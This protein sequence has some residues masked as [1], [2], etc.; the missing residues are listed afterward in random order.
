MSTIRISKLEAARRHLRAAI[1][2][3]FNGAD[4]VV[5]HTLVGVA[6]VLAAD[7]AKH[8]HPDAQWESWAQDANGISAQ[9]Y[10]AI[11]RSTQNFLKHADRDVDA[12]HEFEPIEADALAFG[13]TRNLANFGKLGLEE[14]AFELWYIACNDP[15]GC[16]YEDEI[17]AHAVE[18]FGDL[19][20]QNRDAQL[21]KGRKVLSS[22]PVSKR[23]R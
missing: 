10:F 16:G 18:F 12:V 15:S 23:P 14:S 21:A 7:L 1:V 22:L 5:V 6:S 9:E 17:F 4:P 8:H 13:A 11:A 2:L 20:G 19:R 3:L